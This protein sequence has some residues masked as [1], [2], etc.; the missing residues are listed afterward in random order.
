M[1]HG[2]AAGFGALALV[3]LA[4]LVARGAPPDALGP[5]APLAE[6]QGGFVG[7]MTLAPEHG[8]AGTPVTVTAAGLPA[9]QPVDLVWRTVEGRWNVA[10]AEYHGRTYAPEAYRI[11]AL[12]SDAA[13]HLAA[14]FAAP[15]DFG[16]AHDVTLQQG[17]RLL[18]QAAFSI[19]MAVKL[20]SAS[21]PAGGPI[22]ID[23]TGIGWRELE[24]SWLLRYDNS[25]T[26]W[27][28]A[29]TTRGAAHFAIPAT[30]APG[31]HV[32]EV[33]HGEFTFPYLNPQQNPEPDRPRFGL[34]Y[35][36]T[37]DPPVLPP[38]PAQQAQTA[39]GG[40]PAAGALVAEPRF[41]S[42]GRD[43]VVR[44]S[45]L[46]PGKDYELTWGTVTGNRVKQ[47]GWEESARPIARATA[48]ASGAAAFRFAVPDDLGGAHAVAVKDGDRVLAGNVVIATTALPLDVA[49]GPAG[50]KFTVHLKGV[51]WTETANIYTI[52]YDNNY[53]GYACGFNSQGDVTIQLSASGEPGWHFIDLY[54]AIYKGQENRP[55]NFRIPQLT[56]AADHPGEDLPHFRFAFEVTADGHGEKASLN[57]LR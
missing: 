44:G 29:V 36:I 10:G 48:D 56:Y 55:N 35:T 6:A 31:T 33:M 16:F 1:R 22:A 50:T 20:Q 17:A 25:F 4:P 47:G 41:A 23:V 12:R 43:D 24:N 14:T 54:P 9:D 28:S 42:V 26:G 2:A 5:A 15:D 49:R 3:M 34:L 45:G 53:V 57:L 38:D 39:I 7:S 32:L 46:T 13:G 21:G 8:P 52:V 27:I 37:P 51:G 30:G 19:D 40:L 11:A 18:T